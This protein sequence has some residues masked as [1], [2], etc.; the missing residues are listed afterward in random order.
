MPFI[1]PDKLVYKRN[2]YNGPISTDLHD[3]PYAV[4]EFPHAVHECPHL[5]YDSPTAFPIPHTT[6]IDPWL[7][8]S[9]S[10]D[11]H[12]KVLQ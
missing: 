5:R 7:D 9:H 1:R 10:H 3:H 12:D 2:Y 4:H 8:R 11:Q 6:E